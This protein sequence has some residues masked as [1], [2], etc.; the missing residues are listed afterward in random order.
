MFEVDGVE[1]ILLENNGEHCLLSALLGHAV[2][3]SNL[4]TATTGV[5]LTCTKYRK[6]AVSMLANKEFIGDATNTK[7][8]FSSHQL[9][10]EAALLQAVAANPHER[11][12]T[13]G[14]RSTTAVCHQTATSRCLKS[15]IC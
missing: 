13:C 12:C 1:V 3:K 11:Q 2:S 10:Q 5:T 6:W 7:Q 8:V 9:E 14:R 15:A 4:K